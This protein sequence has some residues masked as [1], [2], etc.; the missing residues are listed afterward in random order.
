[1]C[2]HIPESKSYPRLHKR[3]SN[4]VREMILPP[5]LYSL[6][7]LLVVL[8]AVLE[9]S[10]EERRVFIKANTKERPQN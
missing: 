2:Y 10:I 5:L 4:R 7:S 6:E 1:M 8:S 9:S 3:V